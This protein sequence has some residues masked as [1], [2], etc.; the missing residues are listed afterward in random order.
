MAEV[1]L[2]AGAES[3]PL[4]ER[5][6][7]ERLNV[8]IITTD[9]G[10]A[11]GLNTNVFR[12][13]QRFL[14]ENKDAREVV[15]EVVGRKGRDYFRRRRMAV[16][17]ELPAATGDTAVELARQLAQI[18]VQSIVDGRTDA[19]YLIYNE[20]KSALAQRVVVAPLLPVAASSLV[21]PEAAASGAI[22][23]VYEP[24]KRELLDVLLPLYIESQIHRALLE[25]VASEFGARMTAMDSATNNAKEMIATYTLQYNRARQAAIT[26][27]LMEIVGGAEALK[28]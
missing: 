4:L 13:L 21:P 8:V 9:R 18:V 19:V 22:D 12:S 14:G 23:F 3:H 5:R 24:S 2:R 10:L 20:F 27:E 1:A 7:P 17:H 15:F 25:A 11:G 16:N 26:K 6:A 28:G